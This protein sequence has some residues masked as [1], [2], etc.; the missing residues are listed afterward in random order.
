VSLPS[1]QTRTQ[2]L[3]PLREMLAERDLIL[4]TGKGGTGKSTVV[5]ALAELAARQRG[6]AVA[7][8]MSSHLRLPELLG[9]RSPVRSLNINPEE[10]LGRALGRLLKLPALAG[11]VL[12]NRVLRLFIRTSPAIREMVALDELRVVVEE[13]AGRRHPVVVDL[14]ATGH[15]LS[16][17]DTPRAVREMLRLGPLAQIA[18]DAERLLLDPRRTQ[19]VAVV[20]PEE[21]PVNET[22]ELARRSARIGIASRLVL[23]NQMPRSPL[24]PEDLP[25]LEELRRAE[26]P[27]LT[28]LVGTGQAALEKAA[29]ARLWSERLQ[30]AIDAPLLELPR[31]PSPHP[32]VCVEALVQVLS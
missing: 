4:V 15:A 12:G 6:G 14:P 16:F 28:E 30:R 1:V 27:A 10:V 5:A 23:L 2:P 26:V 13:S 17:L 22:V 11:A 7:V 24:L 31:C 29:A 9:D 18:S 8:E 3:A 32:R 25:V 21:L 19:L 20:I